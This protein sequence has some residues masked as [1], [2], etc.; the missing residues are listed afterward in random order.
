MCYRLLVLP[1]VEH[2]FDAKQTAKE[3][4]DRTVIPNLL[5][6]MD[7]FDNLPESCKPLN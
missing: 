1:T 4:Y 2:F 7:S 6:F 5:S 3:L